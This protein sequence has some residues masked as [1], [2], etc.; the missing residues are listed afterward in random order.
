MRPILDLWKHERG[1]RPFFLALGAGSLGTY[2]GYV[3]IMLVAYQRLGSAWAASLI[4]LADMLPSMVLGPLLGAWLDRR[5]RMRCAIAADVLRAVAI[6]AMVVVPGAPALLVFALVAGFGTA[7]FRPAAFALM[8]ATVSA[9]RLPAANAA[10]GAVQDLGLLLGPAL[11]TGLLL[12]G[13]ASLLLALNAAMFA[14]SALLLT[15][16]R[17]ARPPERE[18]KTGDSLVGETRAGLRMVRRDPILRVLIAGSGAVVVFSGMM[19]VGEVVLAQRELNVGGSG[20]A[21]MVAV[22]GLGTITGSLAS[23]HSE[24]ITRLR[25]GYLLGL[26]VTGAGMIGSALAPSLVWALLSFFV[27]GAGT[28]IAMAHDRGLLQHLVPA[29][30][31]SRSYSLVSTLESWGFA[32]AALLGGA[33]ASTWGGRGLFAVAGTGALVVAAVAARTL[34]RVEPARANLQPAHA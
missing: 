32:V 20:F 11:A 33:L 25:N 12:L 23:A 9:E 15:R 18:A 1:A 14:C 29:R 5:D 31:L 27:T 26:G 28:S 6:A 17:L 13:D 24:G 10:W 8:P 3:A 2:A 21:A 7:V 4:L 34:L 22:F 19:N 30:M 16:V